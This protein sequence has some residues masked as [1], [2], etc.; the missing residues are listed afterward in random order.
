V[1]RSGRPSA[2]GAH[3]RN[4]IGP[5][6]F[7]ERLHSIGGI[8]DH[9][10]E[11]LRSPKPPNPRA[12]AAN[13][14][15]VAQIEHAGRR[16]D[17]L[18]IE[19][20]RM[21]DRAGLDAYPTPNEGVAHEMAWIMSVTNSMKESA[22]RKTW[23]RHMKAADPHLGEIRTMAVLSSGVWKCLECMRQA[24]MGAIGKNPWPDECD[25]CGATMTPGHFN[26]LA[27]NV[28]GCFVNCS[29]CDRCADFQR[30]RQAA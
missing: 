30:E 8:P 27:F 23:C 15:V 5:H 13:D 18:G 12:Q 14:D 7:L 25:L 29:V 22:P 11:D 3:K 24:G 9:V 20:D 4:L 2:R 10:V 28:P 26:E 17:E 6:E 1:S 21:G 16:L 19:H